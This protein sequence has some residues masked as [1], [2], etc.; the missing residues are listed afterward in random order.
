MKVRTRMAPSPTG[1]MHVGGMATLLKNYAFA[2]KHGGEFILRI[3]D[4]DQNRL[5]EGSTERILKTIRAYGLSWDEGPEVGG[6]HQPYYQ[7]ER[8]DIY[9]A[10]AKQLVN[11][12]HAYFCFCSQE[13]LDEVNEKLREQKKP[14]MYDRHCRDLTQSE[15]NEKLSSGSSYVVRLK[16]P[17][18]QEI[19]FS[20]L[21]R[22]EISINSNT[23][24]DQVLLKSD[25]F[26]TYHLGVVVDDHQMEIT[27]IIRGEE[28]ISSTPKHLLLYQAFGWEPPVFAHIP[29]FLNPD[30]KGK[31]SKRKGDVSAQSFLDKGFLPEALLNFFMILGWAAHD[32]REI[33]T[34][35]E[36]INEFDPSDLSP[37]SVAFD[38]KKLEWINGIY[39]RNLSLEELN[40]R[41]E[42]FV[43]TDFP[44]EKLNDV[45]KLV[46]ERLVMLSDFEELSSFF[47]RDIDHDKAELVKKSDSKVVSD[48]LDMTVD[49]LDKVEWNSVEIEKTIRKLQ[50]DNQFKKSQYFMMLRLAVTGKKQTPPLFETIHVLG[51][52]LT[53]ER[54]QQAIK[55][56]N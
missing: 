12:G 44:S 25:G 9:Q 51:K 24:N 38:L 15:V 31:M 36:Y 32:Q 21:I 6:P 2:K 55:I 27:H 26:P 7:S 14:P 49:S 1:E 5:V 18:N 28:W 43:P 53:L 35:D 19:T 50:E 42:P 16:V 30:G 17:D 11:N 47:Y 45:L 40:K 10:A 56:I 48:Q 4:T 29:V 3:E 20:D 13:R 8:L 52:K 33:I 46:S 22:G 39:I 41:I 34:L 54:L 37:K 23:L